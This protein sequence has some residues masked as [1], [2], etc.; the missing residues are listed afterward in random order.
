[1]YNSKAKNASLSLKKLVTPI[2]ILLNISSNSDGLFSI[3][4]K[5]SFIDFNFSSLMRFSNLRF[6]VASL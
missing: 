3:K 1:M 5:Y 6:T 2:N 4:T